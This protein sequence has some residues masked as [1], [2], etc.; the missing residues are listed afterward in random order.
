[1]SFIGNVNYNFKNISKL[2]SLDSLNLSRHLQKSDI[3][4]ATSMFE[5][6]S[7]SL[8]EAIN[9]GCV[10]LARNNSSYP[11]IVKHMGELYDGE[12]D[13]LEKLRNM[14][15]NI[16]YYK[17]D[18]QEFDLNITAKNYYDFAIKVYSSNSVNN[19]VKK[20][21]SFIYYI[22]LFGIIKLY[23][24]FSKYQAFLT[25]KWRKH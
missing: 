7:N 13:I 1:M 23:A 3:F 5:S 20:R 15:K 10:P 22:F 12:N 21:L 6:C 25:K 19:A 17:N 2:A 4:L 11:E 14:S 24:K 8:I 16:E 9:C 18:L